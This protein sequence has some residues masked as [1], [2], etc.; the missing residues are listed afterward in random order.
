MPYNYDLPNYFIYTYE[1]SGGTMVSSNEFIMTNAN[2]FYVSPLKALTIACLDNSL[3]V[4]NTIC[5]IVF[6]TQNPLLANGNIRIVFSG[7]TVATNVCQFILTNGTNLPVT[8]TSTS[9]NKN[10][11]I[12]MSGWQQYP[13]GNFTVIVNGIGIP[14]NQI[15]Q[16]FVL[17]LY[18][19]SANYAI[20]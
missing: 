13:A 8:C 12:S 20:E 4:E 16:S 6:G 14:S 18:D 7:M 15:S 3:G 1:S 19:S 9:D 17:Y 5:T 2:V 10:V 11:T